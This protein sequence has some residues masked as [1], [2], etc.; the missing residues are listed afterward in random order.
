M[1]T[2]PVINWTNE[3]KGNPLTSALLVREIKIIEE[4]RAKRNLETKDENHED[5]HHRQSSDPLDG[6]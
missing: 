4:A 2:T 1:A 6:V 3:F 5:E